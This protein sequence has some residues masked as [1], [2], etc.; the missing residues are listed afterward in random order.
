MKVNI[1]L[2]LIISNIIFANIK[3]EISNTNILVLDEIN[4]KI[5]IPIEDNDSIS[6]K[7]NDFTP[8]ELISKSNKN[9]EIDKH[10]FVEYTFKL[11]I[12]KIGKQIIPEIKFSKIKNK[13]ETE[14]IAPS[15]EITV[16]SVLKNNNDKDLQ[17]KDIKS[18]ISIKEKNYTILYIVI[19][20]LLLIVIF[21]FLKKIKKKVKKEVIIVEKKIPADEIAYKK[22]S[23]LI[24]QELIQKGKV[25]EYF[26]ILSEIIR[27]FI[28][29]RYNFD[30][31]ELT[32][33]ELT[34]YIGQES[35]FNREYL[36]VI[37][38]FLEDSDII[39]FSK[40]QATNEEIEK[41]TQTA[42]KIVDDLK[43]KIMD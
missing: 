7:T 10:K 3:Q 42:F 31:I 36:V 9:I 41:I 21:I 23:E 32:S 17:I 13:I 26:F 20:T 2:L 11:S 14:I 1:F 39:K 18:T 37:N 35:T 38:N 22:L 4:Y 6:L 28:G 19:G 24:N 15:K 8:F 43:I 5:T 27:E 33:N 34:S 29:N 25:K 30:S 16:N 40:I 12:D